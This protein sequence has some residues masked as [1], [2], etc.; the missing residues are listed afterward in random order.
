[1]RQPLM[2]AIA[3]FTVSLA[4]AQH[5]TDYGKVQIR[6]TKV[7]G[8]VYMLEGAGGNIG[9]SVGKTASS[10]STINTRRSRKKSRLL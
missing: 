1:M 9:A 8:T 4:Y 5:D 10:S 3:L 7:A 2:L 6:V